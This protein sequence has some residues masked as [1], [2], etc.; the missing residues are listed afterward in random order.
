M[1]VFLWRVVDF[2]HVVLAVCRGLFVLSLFFASPP[3]GIR[4]SCCWWVFRLP[5]AAGCRHEGV[6]FVSS[7]WGSSCICLRSGGGRVGFVDKCWHMSLRS[8]L[9]CAT[10]WGFRPS[11]LFCLRV[12]GENG[13]RPLF[14]IGWYVDTRSSGAAVCRV[15]G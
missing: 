11:P 8:L 2:R 5:V 3:L 7:V 1:V 14:L 9:A 13:A 12:A 6:R 4:G 10:I 15:R